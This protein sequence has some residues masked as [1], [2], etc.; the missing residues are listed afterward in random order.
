MTIKT[1]ISCC[2]RQCAQGS[3]DKTKVKG[4]IVLC[5]QP[6]GAIE[7]YLS[8]SA[9]AIM[10]RNPGSTVSSVTPLPALSINNNDYTN[11]ISYLKNTKY[12]H[13]HFT[14]TFFA[15]RRL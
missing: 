5:D 13:H 3:L 12:D 1:T 4:K 6:G 10:M 2:F 15:L 9:G 14:L 8:G 11:A 7:A